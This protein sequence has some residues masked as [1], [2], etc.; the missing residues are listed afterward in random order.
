MD[1]PQDVC[2]WLPDDISYSHLPDA[3]RWIAYEVKANPEFI[4]QVKQRVLA[5]R[6]WLE[7]YDISVKSKLG[8][9][10]V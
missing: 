3:E 6:T 5:C 9:I 8:R 10:N 7:L 4:E 1:T 2:K